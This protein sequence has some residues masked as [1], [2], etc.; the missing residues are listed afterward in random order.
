M[1]LVELRHKIGQMTQQEQ[2]AIARLLRKHMPLPAP[3]WPADFPVATELLKLAAL[4]VRYKLSREATI[5]RAEAFAVARCPTLFTGSIV[6][7]RTSP[8]HRSSFAYATDFASIY[9]AL[10]AL[11]APAG[12]MGYSYFYSSPSVGEASKYLTNI[13]QAAVREARLRSSAET[14]LAAHEVVLMLHATASSDLL[15][16]ADQDTVRR[17]AGIRACT[18]TDGSLYGCHSCSVRPL[19]GR[20]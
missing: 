1:W 6:P 12:G 4:R 3:A 19:T 17:L 11:K 16:P 15:P 2:I 20:G 8:A 18:D 5:K 9:D 13:V 7:A 14:A 10:A